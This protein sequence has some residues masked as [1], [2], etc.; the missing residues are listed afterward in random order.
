MNADTQTIARARDLAAIG[1]DLYH[2]GWLPA[3]SGNLSMRLGAE[4]VLITVSGRHKGRLGEADFLVVDLEGR[5]LG[6]GRPSAETLLH[7]RLYAWSSEVDTV[8]HCHSPGATVLSL[9]LSGQPQLT[10]RDYELLKAF[11]GVDSH[12]V[13]REIPIFDNDQDIP[14]LAARVDAWL[15][16]AGNATA[17]PC[18]AYLIRGHGVYAWGDSP[19]NCMRHLEALD[20][21]IQCELLKR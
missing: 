2:R 5:P 4:R 18:P 13:Q 8:L 7:T 10:L 19:D 3:T 11:P 17:P 16:S 15:A 12:T 21:L 6:E 14:R 1:R 9:R 20:F